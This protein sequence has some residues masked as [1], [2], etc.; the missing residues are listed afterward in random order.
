MTGAVSR[1]GDDAPSGLAGKGRAPAALKGAAL[2]AASLHP[3]IFMLPCLIC[4]PVRLFRALPDF[5]SLYRNMPALP[6]VLIP[7]SG[8][9]SLILLMPGDFHSGTGALML[10]TGPAA[11]SRPLRGSGFPSLCRNVNG[12]LAVTVPVTP[13]LTRRGLRFSHPGGKD[14]GL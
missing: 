5:L 3:R 13:P 1:T 9:P 7:V 10:R 4:L 6:G 14:A 12:R 8:I 2:R 11:L